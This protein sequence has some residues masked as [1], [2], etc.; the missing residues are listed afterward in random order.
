MTISFFLTFD[1]PGNPDARIGAAEQARFVS[2]VKATP[3]LPRTPISTTGRRRFS[4]PS[5][6]SPTSRRWRLHW[7]RPVTCRA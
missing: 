2:I 5:S 7:S 4:P 1:Q 3:S 6:I